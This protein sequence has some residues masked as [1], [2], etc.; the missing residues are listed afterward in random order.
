MSSLPTSECS[1]VIGYMNS[2]NSWGSFAQGAYNRADGNYA[3]A[4]GKQNTA[5]W[6]ATATGCANRA[7]GECA[8]AEGGR[9]NTATHAYSYVEGTANRADAAVSHAA[10][11]MARA[12]DQCSFVWNGEKKYGYQGDLSKPYEYMGAGLWELSDSQI[13]ETTINFRDKR[14]IEYVDSDLFVQQM[15]VSHG[16]GTFNVNP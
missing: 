3:F 4:H 14:A 1:F 2:V 12:K 15:Y 10:G 9:A 11:Y 5:S 6:G 8:V 7:L 13:P 16:E